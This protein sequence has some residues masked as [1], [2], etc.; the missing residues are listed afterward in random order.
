MFGAFKNKA[1]KIRKL[2]ENKIARKIL[3]NE[4]MQAQI[5]DLNQQ[6]LYEKGLQAD[7][8]PTGEYAPIT[9]AYYKPL[10]ASEGRDGRSDHITGKDTGETY[11]S[12]QV[13]AK[14]EGFVIAA[15]DRNGFFDVI[16]KGL[17]LTNESIS[18]I[19]PEF[20]ETMVEEV[21]KAI[22]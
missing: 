7:G 1:R 20:R 14:P 16:D 21:R 11:R 10:A 19:R 3:S 8:T 12:M 22:Q 4:S 6:Q 17:G 9:K 13:V 2:D 18:E 5:V 15:D